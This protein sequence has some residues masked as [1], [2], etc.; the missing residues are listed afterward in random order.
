MN[1]FTWTWVY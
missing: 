1:C